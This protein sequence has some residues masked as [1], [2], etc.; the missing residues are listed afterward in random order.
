VRP[1]RRLPGRSRLA[2]AAAFFLL[3]AAAGAQEAG[4][5]QDNSFLIEEAYN[6]EAGVVQ[7]I[8]VL[9]LPRH[10]D[11]WTFDFTQEW[12]LGGLR[13]QL[14]YTVPVVRID[15]EEALGDVALNY[16]YQ[17]VGSG[18]E[19]VAFAPRL[20]LLLPTGDE[21]KG[22]GAGAAGLEVNLPLSVVLSDR[23]VGHW[24]AGGSLTPSA[25]S[26]D[27]AEAD[28]EGVFLGQGLIWLARPR[29][30]VLLEA[31]WERSETVVSEDFIGREESFFVSPG[32][33]LAQ[34][35]ASGLQ[36][37]YGLA[38]PI[39]VGVSDGERSVLLYLSFE[40]PFR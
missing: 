39:G 21:E 35:F 11:D 22:L 29:L 24:N 14:S 25:K 28:V 2:V 26:P 38:A 37:V 23:L 27:G 5:I 20:S 4:P 34:D 15:E 1:A 9:E 31:L 12:P 8:G 10:G 16:R 7:H 3:A 18:E 30:N 36:I 17:L 19:R 13:H 32:L 40:H 6:Q 33:R